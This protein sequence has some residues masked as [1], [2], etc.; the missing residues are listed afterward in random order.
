MN[1]PTTTYRSLAEGL[2]PDVAKQ[3]HSDWYRNEAEYWAVRDSLL[4][5]YENTW[6]AFS[7]GKV[8]AADKRPS[9]V[10]SQARAIATHPFITCVGREHIGL[11]MRRSSFPYDRAYPGEPLPVVRAEFAKAPGS[12]GLVLDDVILDTGSDGSSLP[13]S[14]CKPFNFDLSQG[15]PYMVSGVTGVAVQTVGFVIWVK[16]DGSEYECR[17]Q[18]DFHGSERLLGRDVLNCMDVLFRGP[19][20]EVIINP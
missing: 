17:M 9:I 4:A 1:E 6:L 8:I 5:Q 11:R 12:R 3:I 14:D 2:P 13:W 15:V 16:L 19:A 18:I 7:D 20:A 10:S